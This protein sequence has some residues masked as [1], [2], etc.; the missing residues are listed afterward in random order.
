MPNDEMITNVA[1]KFKSNNINS[2]FGLKTVK[3]G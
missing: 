2:L 1:S 3:I